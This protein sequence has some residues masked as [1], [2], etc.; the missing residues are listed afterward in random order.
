VILAVKIVKIRR[1]IVSFII[2]FYNSNE[3]LGTVSILN[4]TF[5]FGVRDNLLKH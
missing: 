4:E 1:N 2:L 5:D 3:D